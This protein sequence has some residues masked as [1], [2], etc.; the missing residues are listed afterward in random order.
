ME[1]GK[2]LRKVWVYYRSTYCHI[3]DVSKLRRWDSFPFD[4]TALLCS[5]DDDDDNDNDKYL[6]HRGSEDCTR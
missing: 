1:V 3:P 4:T 2:F 6:V 5:D